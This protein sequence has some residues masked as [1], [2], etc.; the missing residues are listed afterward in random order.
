[1]GVTTKIQW[2]DST[3]NPTMGC[4]GCEL[5]N[6]KTG[7]LT[8][9]AGVL[10]RRYGGKTKGFSPTFDQVTF[11]KGRMA[12]AARWSDLADTERN[13][14]P[15]LDGMPRLIFVSD[16][17]DALSSVVPFS[18]LLEEVIRPVT[19]DKGLR[20]CWLWLTK[21]PDR[22]AE[23][24]AHLAAQ[25]VSWPQNLW[26]GTSVTTQPTTT[27][28]R[29]LL[30]VGDE[31]TIRFVSVEPQR[32]AI[33]LSRWIGELDWIIQGGESG[34]EA[35]P[36]DV[37]WV[38][39]LLAQCRAAGTAYFLK[40]LG[41]V[42]HLNGLRKKF[43]DGHAGDWDEWPIDIRVRELPQ[44]VVMSSVGGAAVERKI[45]T[46]ETS[47]ILSK[48]TQAALKA[49]ATRRASANNEDMVRHS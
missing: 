26:A 48:G 35:H 28:V 30:R 24:S 5:W 32:E 8:C 25:G 20:H 6:P 16:M 15:W 42:V 37:A 31:N 38:R 9:Y 39:H 29:H 46:R 1:M 10:H 11:W 49:W 36:F 14:K 3:C 45:V 18:F 4:E 27:R 21:R 22:M 2:C 23:F 19:S 40:Q 41:S 17:S 44:R 13:D 47:K 12:E 7:D 34:A 33:D 43:V